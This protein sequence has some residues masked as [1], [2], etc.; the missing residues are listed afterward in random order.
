MVIFNDLNDVLRV[1]IQ[2]ETI[3]VLLLI[4]SD[5]FEVAESFAQLFT[6]V[7]FATMLHQ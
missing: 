1:R 6:F 5:E 3:S 4:G 2:T 7:T